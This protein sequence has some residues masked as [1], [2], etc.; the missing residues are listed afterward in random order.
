MGRFFLKGETIVSS[1]DIP[2]LIDFDSL[3]S[4]LE[5]ERKSLLKINN[6]SQDDEGFV[7]S[8]EDANKILETLKFI[9]KD[10]STLFGEFPTLMGLFDTEF[11]AFE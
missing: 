8:T 2:A 6:F 10:L 1:T 9:Q 11:V 4:I 7:R 3:S 5:S